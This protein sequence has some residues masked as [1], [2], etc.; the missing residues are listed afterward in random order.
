MSPSPLRLRELLQRLVEAEI[1]FILVGGLAVNAWGYIRSTQDVDVVPDPN[2]ENLAKL[3]ELLQEL[4]GKVDVGGRLLDSS[5]ISTFLRTGDRTFV[6][7][8]LGQVDVLQGLPQVPRYEELEK[9]A[10]EIDIDG[11]AVRVCSL[12]HLLEMKRASDRARDRDDIE[13]LEAAQEPRGELS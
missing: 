9:G 5:S 7:T 4:G 8:E 2:P 11:L 6:R 3:D 12:E 1:S 10:K 13:A